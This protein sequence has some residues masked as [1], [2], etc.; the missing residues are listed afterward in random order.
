M[1]FYACLK[2]KD[3]YVVKVPF[4]SREEAREYIEKYFDPNEHTECWTE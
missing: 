1:T 3:G 2:F 4:K